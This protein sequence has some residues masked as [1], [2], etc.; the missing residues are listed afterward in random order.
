M[1]LIASDF[2]GATVYIDVTI[3][4]PVVVSSYHL[5]QAAKKPGY[6]ALR[7]EYGKRQRYAVQNIVPF[8]IELGG[9]PGPTALKFIRELFRTDGAVRDQGIADAWST[10][11]S[12]L[13]SATATQI[14]K[15]GQPHQQH[16]T[17]SNTQQQQPPQP[18]P[19]PQPQQPPH[20][21]QPP[22]AAAG[23]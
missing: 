7:A 22:T 2:A 15:T 10:L 11:S 14:N 1:D 21:N 20:A 23:T 12:A 4:S 16:H 3:V 8:A 9:R 17:T 19:Q 5:M 6:A 18:Q 13:H